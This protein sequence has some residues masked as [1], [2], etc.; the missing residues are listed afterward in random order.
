MVFRCSC[1]D[2]ISI[3]SKINVAAPEL[4]TSVCVSSS[5]IPFILHLFIL[6]VL[7]GFAARADRVMVYLGSCIF[8]V[9]H[10]HCQESSSFEVIF[11]LRLGL[12]VHCGI[13]QLIL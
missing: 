7:K 13:G 6:C 8:V 9:Q 10:L 11:I 12:P 1:S 5:Y 2:A 3:I 4:V